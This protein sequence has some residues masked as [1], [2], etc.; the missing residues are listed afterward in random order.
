MAERQEMLRWSLALRLCS[1]T[2]VHHKGKD[3][4]VLSQTAEQVKSMIGEP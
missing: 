3:K 1:F 2:V 4:D